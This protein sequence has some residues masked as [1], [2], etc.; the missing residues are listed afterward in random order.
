MV[1][2]FFFL[3]LLSLPSFLLLH[4]A[5]VPRRIFS[6]LQPSAGLL[7][8]GPSAPHQERVFLFRLAL[9]NWPPLMRASRMR[10]FRLQPAVAAPAQAAAPSGCMPVWWLSVC[11]S[12]GLQYR[13]ALGPID[14]AEVN[15]KFED[16]SIFEHGTFETPCAA[17]FWLRAA[18]KHNSLTHQPWMANKAIVAPLPAVSDPG[19]QLHA[20][21]CAW[22]SLVSL[23]LVV[24]PPPL[25][26]RSSRLSSGDHAAWATKRFAFT[27][28]CLIFSILLVF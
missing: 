6:A 12:R 14:A 13:S 16:G 27:V 15:Q 23:V 22:V 10:V 28:N 8:T 21:G 20:E 3:S 9:Q 18:P 7:W 11:S 25:C 19:L 24:A 4:D 17:L 2:V 26:P 5:F 1:H